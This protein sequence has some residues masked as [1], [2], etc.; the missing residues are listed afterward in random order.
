[1][2]LRRLLAAAL[3]GALVGVG[4]GAPL[5]GRLATPT[6]LDPQRWRIIT[7]GLREGVAQ[8]SIG[9]GT[10][11]SGGALVMTG[12]AFFRP[13]MLVA[14]PAR[15][16]HHVTIEFAAGSGP[17]NVNLGSP[18]GRVTLGPGGYR[19]RSGEPLAGGGQRWQLDLEQGRFTLT[20]PGGSPTAFGEGGPGPLELSTEGAQARIARIQLRG[21]DGAVLL[22]EDFTAHRQ[23]GRAAAVGAAVGAAAGLCVGLTGP[24][25]LLWLA[26]PALVALV[27]SS[28]WLLLAERLY[29]ADT[30][31][32]ELARLGLAA[33]FLPLLSAALVQTPLFQSTLPAHRHDR[34]AKALWWAAAAAAVLLASHTPASGADVLLLLPGVVLVAAMGIAGWRLPGVSWLGRDLPLLAALAVTGWAGVGVLIWGRL[35]ILGGAVKALL[36]DAPRSA[37]NL[38]LLLAVALPFGAEVALRE[39]YLEAAWDATRLSQELPA[40]EGWQNV[41]ASWADRCPDGAPDPRR[42]V[43]LGGSSTGGAYQFREEAAAFFAAQAHQQLCGELPLHTWNYGTGDGNTF[44][45]SRTLRHV[46]RQT[47]AELLVMYVGVNDLL[48]QHHPQTRKEREAAQEAQK[49]ATRGLLGLARRLRLVTGA[50][51]LLK[52]LPGQ[53]ENVS[54]VPISDAEENHH[55]IAREAAEH[56]ARVVLMTE[57]ITASMAGEMAGYAE[58]QQRIAA[59]HD[60]VSWIDAQRLLGIDSPDGLLVD[61]N[62][63]SR[64]GNARLG[65][66]LA[67]VI[68]RALSGVEE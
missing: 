56:G 2:S 3:V 55:L 27:P 51:L 61:R 60:H 40:E 52:P 29:L 53:E 23:R 64:D 8:H 5:E 57:M 6:E 43:F 11:V 4:L 15:D 65:A 41:V 14:L 13:D 24:A 59:A 16:P 35:L 44:T 17:V 48:T 42:V 67:P 49:R 34:I 63:L 22:E 37:A 68:R 9:R 58:M 26:L 10:H 66:A 20:P 21:Q 18:P 30:P 33:S 39:T 47:G 45:I 28:R 36:R 50:S 62:H 1:M 54:T 25:G 19:A 46:F 12:H 38:L 31:A 7:P 32:W